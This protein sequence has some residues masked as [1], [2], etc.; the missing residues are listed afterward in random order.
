MSSTSNPQYYLSKK[1]PLVSVK[2]G[3]ETEKRID[4]F[5]PDGYAFVRGLQPQ[6]Q[7]QWS[8]NTKL[9]VIAH[10]NFGT[11]T[12]WWLPLFYNGDEH[13]FELI[14]GVTVTLPQANSSDFNSRSSIP[15]RGSR[16]KA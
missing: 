5:N 10:Q 15:G 6:K 9:D 16:V 1:F 14:N 7:I 12:A 8:D 13:P 11:V 3:R 4:I 2:I